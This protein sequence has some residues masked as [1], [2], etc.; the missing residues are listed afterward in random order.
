MPNTFLC[1]DPHFGHAGMA[2]FLGK[3]GKKL[4]PYDTVEEMDEALVSNWNG[5]V[6]AKDK[7]YLLGD[8]AINKKALQV[9]HRLNGD[10]VLVK[11][12]HDTEKLKVYSEFFRDIRGS[13]Q[14]DGMLLTHIPVHPCSLSRWTCNV[15][16]HL[17][18]REIMRHHTDGRGYKHE[19][20]DTR[21]FCVSMEHINFTPI[22]LEDLKIKI[23]ERQG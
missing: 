8:V 20:I 12:N 1:A 15:H 18:D 14:L 6:G 16:G 23:K 21:Y 5:V 3:D 9:L 13:H 7:V 4:R 17:H 19:Y 11:G 22:A 10:K 2:T